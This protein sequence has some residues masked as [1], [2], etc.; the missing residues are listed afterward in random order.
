MFP[1]INYLLIFSCATINY[2]IRNYLITNILLYQTFEDIDQGKH[3]FVNE[4]LRLLNE[5]GHDF[6]I[7]PQ[8]LR[9]FIA[10]A[11]NDTIL[12]SPLRDAEL[13]LKINE[14]ESNFALLF[15]TPRSWE[16]LKDLCQRYAI[17]KYRI[18]D[19]NIAALVIA[20]EL[21]W[22]WTFNLKD[23]QAIVEIHLLPED[24]E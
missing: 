24:N 3:A 12:K 11:T 15:E 8:I 23:F 7:A 17:K 21:D 1:D 6:Y 22:L 14:F 2:S 19:A 5:Q 16:M 18:H 20:Y 13:L 10:L 9:E 4:R